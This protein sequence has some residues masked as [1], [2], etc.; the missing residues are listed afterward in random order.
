MRDHQNLAFV[1][2]PEDWR[3]RTI[4]IWAAAITLDSGLVS[5]EF[6]Q[7]GQVPLRKRVITE[8]DTTASIAAWLHQNV[9]QHD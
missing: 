9:I 6:K 7:L 8:A 5:K 3:G 4:E 2:Y 1:R